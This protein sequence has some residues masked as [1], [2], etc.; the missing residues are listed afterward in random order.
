MIDQLAF[1]PITHGSLALK[2]TNSKTCRG[3]NTEP[4]VK[5]SFVGIIF[6]LRVLGRCM[7]Q[8]EVKK[9]ETRGLIER[10]K[11]SQRDVS[12]SRI[13]CSRGDRHQS[14]AGRT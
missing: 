7:S 12:I 14:E 6:G 1:K 10:H 4:I 11:S 9:T 5:R 13:V 3:K 8:G 2:D